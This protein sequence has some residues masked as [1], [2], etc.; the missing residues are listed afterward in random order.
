MTKK[1]MGVIYRAFKEGKL[2]KTTKDDISNMYYWVD[3]FTNPF[4]GS[5]GRS[6]HPDEYADFIDLKNAVKAIFEGDYVTAERYTQG[7]SPA[8]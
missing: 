1:M 2:V 7:F 3:Y 6:I 4:N 8:A 5:F